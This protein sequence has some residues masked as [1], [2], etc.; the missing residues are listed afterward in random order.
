MS[1]SADP[2]HKSVKFRKRPFELPDEVG[3]GL[4]KH[5]N[6][7]WMHLASFLP[8]LYIAENRDVIAPVSLW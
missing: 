7:E 5:S 1:S 4:L 2:P 6:T 8:A 3:L